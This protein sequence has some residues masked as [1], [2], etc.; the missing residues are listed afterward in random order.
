MAS[1]DFSFIGGGLLN[2]ASDSGAVVSGGSVNRARGKYSVVAG[3]GGAL[4]SDSNLASGDKSAIVGGQRNIAS[5]FISFI[6]GGNGNTASG[7]IGSVVCGG[8]G[9]TASQIFATVGGGVSNRASSNYS[10]VGGG[11][12]NVAS[13]NASTIG[14]GVVNFATGVA[15][16]IPGGAFCIAAGDFSFAA[17]VRAH[18]DHLG[19]FVWA[20]STNS[21]FSFSSTLKNQF[22]VRATGGTRFFSNA[23][24]TAGVLLAPGG[25]TWSS[26]S[27]SALKRNIRE[28]DYQEVLEKVVALPIS[29]WSYE[30]QD[31]SIEHIGPMAQDF[32]RLFGLGEDDKHI[33]TLDPDGVALAAI[34]ALYE[35]NKGLNG[36]LEKLEELVKKLSEK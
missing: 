24:L 1:G 31:E 28:V 18:A 25:S 10:T 15:S 36:R 30:A 17:G 2:I 8:S 4:P 6:G 34:K 26:V 3:G 12:S 32:Y 29:Q 20:D 16:T 21:N 27:D 9:N 5:G 33:N 13:G 7:D 11:Q 14:G 19:T 35:E 22:S 23:G